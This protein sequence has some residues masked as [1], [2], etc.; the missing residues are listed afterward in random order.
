MHCWFHFCF[1]NGPLEK[2]QLRKSD[3]WLKGNSCQLDHVALAEAAR[4]RAS[5]LLGTPLNPV[6]KGGR[7]I[8]TP[9]VEELPVVLEL[10]AGFAVRSM[11]LNLPTAQVP[12]KRTRWLE[13]R[14]ESVL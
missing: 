14:T 9:V 5:P 8:L 13:L 6:E 1:Q 11:E 2:S 4:V 7:P 3:S 12:M 10:T